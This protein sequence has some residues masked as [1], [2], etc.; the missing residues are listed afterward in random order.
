MPT[1]Y[2]G[3]IDNFNDPTG[4]NNLN[5]AP[6]LHSALHSNV[7]DAINAIETE[8]GINPSAASASVADRLGLIDTAL[9]QKALAADEGAANG[10][11][12]LDA[13]SKLV[14]D[15]DAAKLTSG[16]VPVARI[17]NLSGAKILGTGSGGAAIALDAVPNLPAARTTSGI[18]DVARIPDLDGAKITSGTIPAARIPTT[19]TSNANATVVADTAARDA[20]PL[21]N[22][23]NGQL[24]WVSN[25]NVMYAWES[26]GS[27]WNAVGGTAEVDVNIASWLASGV[28]SFSASYPFHGSYNVASKRFTLEAVFSRSS[29]SASAI[30]HALVN[31]PAQYQ[32]VGGVNAVGAAP[33]N[34]GGGAEKVA[35]FTGAATMSIIL[36]ATAIFATGQFAMVNVSWIT[37]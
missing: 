30:I 17:P 14:Q 16:L 36:P 12:T 18:F 6:V 15:V 1:G 3:A 32:P 9:G 5:D 13:G 11:A 27:T 26:A 7:N 21:A 2:P 4:A 29:N 28:V 37:A 31:V 19:V 24:V 22:R 23:V 35:R 33:C 8:L 25:I 34:V 20:I 10:I